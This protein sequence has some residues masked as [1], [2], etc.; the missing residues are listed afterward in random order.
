MRVHGDV[1]HELAVDLNRAA[2]L[3]RLDVLPCFSVVMAGSFFR[4]V[5]NAASPTSRQ[6]VEAFDLARRK[7]AD[8][9]VGAAAIGNAQMIAISFGSGAS[10]SVIVMPS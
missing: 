4:Y 8:P 10:G 3:E 5:R 1:G 7:A 2:V 9:M 6:P